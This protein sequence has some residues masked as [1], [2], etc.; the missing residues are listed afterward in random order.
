[1]P[2]ADRAS[3]VTL[4]I[5][6]LT[7]GGDAPGLNAAI[8]AVVLRATALGHELLGIA[9]GWAGLL[10]EA[11]PRPLGVRDANRILSE[12]GTILG[13]S[14][15]DPRK[16]EASRRAVLDSIRRWRIDAL[17]AIGGDHTPRVAQ[18]L[19]QHR[20][21]ALGAPATGR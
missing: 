6:V 1:M 11:E 16:D 9:D 12:G 19:P 20:G 18:W 10:G 13:T 3:P 14:R 7:G 5:G 8:R 21:R 4:R 15:T 2:V 17:V